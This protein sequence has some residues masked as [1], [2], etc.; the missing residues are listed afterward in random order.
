MDVEVVGHV[1]AVVVLRRRVA[2]VQP[3]GVD[4]EIGEVIEPLDHAA[5]VTDAVTVGIGE[6]P[7]V[8]LVHDRVVPPGHRTRRHARTA[9][10]RRPARVAVERRTTSSS[11][12]R[13]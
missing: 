12:S 1:V 9:T 11:A 10:R 13:S 7:H 5:Q 4:A 6:R 2:R 3:D 8:Q